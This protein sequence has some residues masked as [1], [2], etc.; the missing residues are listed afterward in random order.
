VSNQILFRL[1]LLRVGARRFLRPSN[2]S[3][4]DVVSPISGVYD[5][6]AWALEEERTVGGWG[7]VYSDPPAAIIVGCFDEEMP[8]EEAT[9]DGACLIFPVVGAPLEQNDDIVVEP[10]EEPDEEQFEG[11]TPQ[12]FDPWS[13]VDA[14]VCTVGDDSE[15]AQ[16]E[17]DASFGNPF[18]DTQSIPN[19]F[20]VISSTI[21]ADETDEERTVGG[22]SSL[23][24]TPATAALDY[25]SATVDDGE[26]E[27]EWYDAGFTAPLFDG[28]S[29]VY[30]LSSVDDDETPEE[31]TD[32]W[33]SPLFDGAS[34]VDAIRGLVDDDLPEEE[35]TEDGEDGQGGVYSNPPTLTDFIVSTVDEDEGG[36]ERTVG[37][38]SSLY[39]TP[40]VTP[41]FEYIVSTP[42]PE[43]EPEEA[44]DDALCHVFPTVGPPPMDFVQQGVEPD[45]EPS[46]EPTY[47]GYGVLYEEEPG[48]QA[49]IDDDLP[50]EEPTEDWLGLVFG[51][52]AAPPLDY[53]VATVD[54]DE[55]PEEATEDGA[56]VWTDPAGPQPDWLGFVWIDDEEPE[57]ETDAFV[58]QVFPDVAPPATDFVPGWTD[59]DETPEEATDDWTSIVYDDAPPVLLD[60]VC[61]T[62]DDDET[63][64]EPTEDPAF[65]FMLTEDRPTTCFCPD[66]ADVRLGV[67]YGPT[68]T[69]YTGTLVVGGGGSAYT[70]R[71][72]K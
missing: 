38:A 30:G 24:D 49:T 7:S 32:D 2:G 44:T 43:E 26:G 46:E 68:G 5:D 36:E 59:D 70:P 66:P 27:D 21:D 64:E 29:T 17:D 48:F 41:T 4:P 3:S 56:A 61:A 54:D 8:D 45:E 60:Y 51:V 28:F 55:T 15:E 22:A 42:G 67:M 62:V 35:P 6:E 10:Y 33:T 72:S 58:Y 25:V 39:D 11:W 1:G 23:Y 65:Q 9:E 14:I 63:P 19:P 16:D 53:V 34:T 50:E 12:L 57:E 71:R 47:G 40:G 18:V 52:V 13:T 69:E 20:E 37:G 31:A